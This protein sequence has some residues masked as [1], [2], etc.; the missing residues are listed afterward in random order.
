MRSL[1]IAAV[2]LITGCAAHSSVEVLHPATVGVP[3]H[4]QKIAIVDRSSPDNV[5][6]NVLGALEGAITGEGI[7]ADREGRESAVT[8]L[9]WRLR[10]GDRYEI[11]VPNV[12]PKAVDSGVFDSQMEWQKPSASATATAAT[13]SWRWRPS[14]ATRTS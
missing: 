11:I 3:G 7:M 10:E 5:G 8:E 9:A 2:A 14:T 13:R 1:L 4:I 12:D 6:Q